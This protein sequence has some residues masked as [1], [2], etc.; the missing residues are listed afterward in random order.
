MYRVERYTLRLALEI[1]VY[2]CIVSLSH[3]HEVGFN[4]LDYIM[5][6]TNIAG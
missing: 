5:N 4:Q 2:F 1:L 3:G 6:I